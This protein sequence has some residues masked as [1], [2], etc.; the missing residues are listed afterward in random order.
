MVHGPAHEPIDNAIE[1]RTARPPTSSAAS[2]RSSARTSRLQPIAADFRRVQRAA[3][4]E[5]GRRAILHWLEAGRRPRPARS[6]AS[7]RRSRSPRQIEQTH[8]RPRCSCASTRI[9]LD[10]IADRGWNAALD[11]YLEVA[12]KMFGGLHF[13]KKARPRRS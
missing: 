13:G 5:R 8:A 10:A 9:R 7:R 12:G 3:G 1:R 4:D 6:S 2:A 11:R